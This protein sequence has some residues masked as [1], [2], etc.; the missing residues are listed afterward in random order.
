MNLNWRRSREYGLVLALVH[1]TMIVMLWCVMV[2]FHWEGATWDYTF[3]LLDMP[4]ARAFEHAAKTFGWWERFNPETA[5]YPLV[6]LFL[7][8]LFW[9]LIGMV[10]GLV[11]GSR[12]TS[13]ATRT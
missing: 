1:S 7:G 8:G 10:L 2:A 13:E 3:G 11:A 6:Y 4:V 12:S 9:L 5:L